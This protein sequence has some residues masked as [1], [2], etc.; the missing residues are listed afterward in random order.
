[1]STRMATESKETRAL[2]KRMRDVGA[3]TLSIVGSV[4]QG[5]GWPDRYLSH[6][7]L[8]PGGI[9]MEFKSCTGRVKRIQRERLEHLRRTGARACVGRFVPEGLRLETPDGS[10]IVDLDLDQPIRLIMK[11]IY[12]STC[13]KA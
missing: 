1:M 6:P 4:E 8:G 12:D 5:A 3:V 2:C 7:L 13:R 9:W 10:M 11:G